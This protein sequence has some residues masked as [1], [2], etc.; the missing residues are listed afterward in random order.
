MVRTVHLSYT[1]PPRHS[2]HLR[3]K[4]GRRLCRIPAFPL[5]PRT[6]SWAGDMPAASSRSFHSPKHSISPLPAFEGSVRRWGA[7]YKK[8]PFSHFLCCNIDQSPGTFPEAACGDR[9]MFAKTFPAAEDEGHSTFQARVDFGQGGRNGGQPLPAPG[10]DLF[11]KGLNH[12]WYLAFVS[13]AAPSPPPGQGAC[14]PKRR[15]SRRRLRLPPPSPAFS[16]ISPPVSPRS[17]RID[18]SDAGPLPDLRHSRIPASWPDPAS[19]PEPAR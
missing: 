11:K 7:R 16:A 18:P 8:H 12:C 1:H 5:L 9:R 17:V 3:R 2:I 13:C 4:A 14:E 15:P 19:D 10:Q 6:P